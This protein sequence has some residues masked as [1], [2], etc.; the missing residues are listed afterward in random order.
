MSRRQGKD[1]ADDVDFVGGGEM[2]GCRARWAG[3]GGNWDGIFG[4]KLSGFG[5]N[6]R[7]DFGSP[8]LRRVQSAVQL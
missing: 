8:C 2:R 5:A 7:A 1:V 4:E 3:K 6:K